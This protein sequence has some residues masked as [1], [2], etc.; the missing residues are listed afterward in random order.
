M[1]SYSE[2]IR[3]KKL[4]MSQQQFVQLFDDWLDKACK[5]KSKEI[6]N[7]NTVNSFNA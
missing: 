1:E 6:I 7:N 3:L 5:H 4:K 2:A